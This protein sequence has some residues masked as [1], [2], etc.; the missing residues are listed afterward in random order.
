MAELAAHEYANVHRGIHELSN[1]ATVAYEAAR[2]RPAH[3][4]NAPQE[5]CIVFTRGITESINLVVN[6]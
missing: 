5:G 4:L 6:T 2:T 1:S 3:F